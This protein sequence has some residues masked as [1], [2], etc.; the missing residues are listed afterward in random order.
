MSYKYIKHKRLQ[1]TPEKWVATKEKFNKPH[2][3]M[4]SRFR[5]RV[6]LKILNSH[7]ISNE[8]TSPIFRQLIEVPM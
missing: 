2:S 6:N 3:P 7:D 5:L 4:V 1:D 8:L